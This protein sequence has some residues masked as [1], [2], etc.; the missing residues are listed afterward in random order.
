MHIY[1][2]KGIERKKGVQTNL[3]R[4][5][6]HRATKCPHDRVGAEELGQAEVVDLDQRLVCVT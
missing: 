2:L 6:V 3:G 5:V 4:R 1:R